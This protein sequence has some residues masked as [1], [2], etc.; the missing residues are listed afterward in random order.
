M[1]RRKTPEGARTGLRWVVALT[2]AISLISSWSTAKA[3]PPALGYTPKEQGNAPKNEGKSPGP[4][5]EYD[6]SFPRRVKSG[7]S[8]AA[9]PAIVGT[10]ATPGSKP[11]SDEG[12]VPAARTTATKSGSSLAT[13]VPVTDDLPRSSTRA[14][15]RSRESASA[16]HATDSKANPFSSLSLSDHGPIDIHSDSLA[17]DYKGSTVWFKGN[18]HATQGST[19]LASDVL[20]V[21]YGAN[22][23]EIKQIVAEGNVKLSQGGRFATGDKAVLNQINHTVEMTGNPVIHDGE[24][25]VTGDSILIYLDTQ[26]T[27]IKGAKAKIF[28]HKSETRDNNS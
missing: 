15:L 19:A 4:G 8:A 7:P 18:V 28:P 3:D 12:F 24:D 1:L 2:L 17:M 25:E 27:E 6:S 16:D 9:S 5:W 13:A 10:P 23:K 11:S 14:D 22:L 21:L 26:K 20:S